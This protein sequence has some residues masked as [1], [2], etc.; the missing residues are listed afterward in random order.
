MHIQC[1]Y[2][3]SV[4]G[5]SDLLYIFLMK[6]N[7]NTKWRWFAEKSITH[8]RVHLFNVGETIS[9]KTRTRQF[10]EAEEQE[11]EQGMFIPPDEAA[12]LALDYDEARDVMQELW[13]L[14][15]RPMGIESSNE[16]IQSLK[17]HIKTL[18]H[19]V[20]HL[21]GAVETLLKKP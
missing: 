21:Q 18:H 5:D 3:H 12:T 14:G 4:V 8:Q 7:D 17:D 2:L 6:F 11:H 19:Q 10:K 20:Q 16:Y 15:F 9:G 13:N 1:S